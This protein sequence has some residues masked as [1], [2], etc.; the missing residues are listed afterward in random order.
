LSGRLHTQPCDSGKLWACYFS[1]RLIII[2]I[3]GAPGNSL[4][5]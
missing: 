3:S 1:S 5:D 2:V 4:S